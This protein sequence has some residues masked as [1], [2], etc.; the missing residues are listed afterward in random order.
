MKEH[1]N[2]SD[3]KK[4]LDPVLHYEETLMGSSLVLLIHPVFDFFII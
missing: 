2:R 3:I 4:F 1:I